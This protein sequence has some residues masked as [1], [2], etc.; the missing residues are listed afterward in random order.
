M[1]TSRKTPLKNLDV[2]VLSSLKPG[3][4]RSLTGLALAVHDDN[5]RW[6]P[7]GSVDLILTDPPFNIARDTNFHTYEKNTIN[8]Y[9]FD[10]DKGWDTYTPESFRDLLKDWSKEFSRVLR[11][12][13]SFAIFCA[14]AYV[15]H[16]IDALKAAGLSPRRVLTWRKPNAVPINRQSLMMSACEYVVIGVRGSSATFNSDVYIEGHDETSLLEQVLIADKVASI[17]DKEVR[18]ALAAVSSVGKAHIRDVETAVRAALAAAATDAVKRTRAMFTVDDEGTLY[19]RG[20]VP[21]YVSFNSKT[22]ARLHPTEKPLPLLSYLI[23][24]LSKPGDIILD[25]FGGSGSTAEAAVTLGR[26]VVAV[27]RDLE[28]YKKISARL[29]KAAAK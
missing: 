20:C 28:F 29:K 22:G 25:P 21:N 1:A 9:R 27:E 12:G 2:A 24:L 6:L 17:V 8:S 15:S 11:P 10:K 16:L 23:T 5:F 3:A 13:G 4:H 7:D 18:S 14:D 19:L 26:T